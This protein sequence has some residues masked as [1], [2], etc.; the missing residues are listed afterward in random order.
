MHT[1]ATLPTILPGLDSPTPGL[2]RGM[3]YPGDVEILRHVEWTEFG[4]GRVSS[5]QRR[6]RVPRN[7]S[8]PSRGKP[9][10]T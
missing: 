7:G 8:A 3:D 6:A 9:A 2:R 10:K 1:T 5:R 4:Q